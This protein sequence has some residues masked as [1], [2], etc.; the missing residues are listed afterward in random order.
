[1]QIS[2]IPKDIIT[3]A[4]W[5]EHDQFWRDMGLYDF[6]HLQ[7]LTT[8]GTKGECAEF[9]KN[10]TPVASLVGE[11]VIHL[12]EEDLAIFFHLGVGETKDIAARA[13]S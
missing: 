10:A 11:E 1:M 5:P 4:Q 6:V 12:L 8:I 9:I 7:W 2:G 3:L 13:R